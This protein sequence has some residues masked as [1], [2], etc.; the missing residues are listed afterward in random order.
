MKLTSIA[1]FGIL[2]FLFT[3]C[4]KDDKILND[5][6]KGNWVAATD[7]T[8]PSSNPPGEFGI[9]GTN[10]YHAWQTCRLDDTFSFS[11]NRLII[12]DNGTA[13]END[14]DLIFEIKDQPYSYDADKKQLT[15][16]S[17]NNVAVMDVLELDN[18]R[19]KLGIAV[20]SGTG[21][22]RIIFLF[23]RN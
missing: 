15:I 17:G 3:G 7:D 10:Q 21:F 20:P 13:C 5:L 18:E 2:I 9:N 16:G 11:K 12:N 1:Y 23:K 8:N 19:L 6:E 4:S 14:Y 22:K